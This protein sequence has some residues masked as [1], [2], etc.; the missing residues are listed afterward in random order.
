M[1]GFAGLISPSQREGE[2]GLIGMVTAMAER[3][4]HRGPDDHGAWA[5]AA[6]GV[7]LAHRRLSIVDLSPSGHQPMISQC[8]RYVIAFNGE[9]YN[10]RQLRDQLEQEC[11]LQWR[12]HSDTEV[13]LAAVSHWGLTR[14]LERANGMFAL[15]LWDRQ[16]RILHLA[17]DRA[18]EKPLY[19]GWSGGRF[20]FAS[21]L[22]ALV[23]LPDWRGEVDKEA[24]A[25]Y[26]RF[27]YVP[28]P[29]SIYRGISK[30][31]PGSTLSLRSAGNGEWKEEQR[32]YWS[33][34]EVAA[35]GLADPLA[36]PEREASAE[37]E[38]LLADAVALRMQADV[39]LGALLSGG[40]DS[41]LVV[42]LMQRQSQRPVRT[43]S[44][45]F[46]DGEFDES[47]A[48]EAVAT[49][50][51]TEHSTL[52]LQPR[53]LLAAV[54]HMAAIYDEPFADVSQVPTYLIS[55]FARQQVTVALSGDGGDELFFGYKR[56]VTGQSLW[57][58]LDRLPVA[59][60]RMVAATLARV[61]VGGANR[62]SA[63]FAA[64][65]AR[66]GRPGLLGD[67]LRKL[68]ELVGPADF[69]AFYRDF[70]SMWKQPQELLAGESVP[71]LGGVAA[72]SAAGDDLVA[73]MALIDFETYLP[74]DILV[75]V[76][77][78]SM[79]TS[80]E[81]RVPLLDHRLVEFAWRLPTASK[82]AGGQGKHVLREVLYRNVPRDLVDRP[83]KGFGVPL[84]DWLRGPLREWAGDLLDESRLRQQGLLDPVPVRQKWREHLSGDRNW[85]YQLWG[86]L[87]LQAW[88]EHHQ[89]CASASS[90][91]Q[92]PCFQL[93]PQR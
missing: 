68:A 9:I 64:L 50:L 69:E 77:R 21:E 75:K 78:A 8:Q 66:H 90:P 52:H 46:D 26:L 30:L 55:R 89:S 31:M 36:L 80:L 42:A 40:V 12:G 71:A 18:G 76:D 22:K 91:A 51:G 27:G 16:E 48:A 72:A 25:Q 10:F 67:K 57:R 45:G 37:L 49:R 17:R 65:M 20:A 61:P 86:V 85:A 82:L 88:L 44:V 24:L 38:S 63:P 4:R 35:A 15:A 93:T 53:D 1:C 74:D 6:A 41:S 43:F 11:R 47:A 29:R 70:V 14:A 92:Q 81:V 19:Y 28:A 59:V 56:Y 79:A 60:R 83:K 7:A 3:L 54:P 73:R 2:Q 23:G 34:A 32:R 33:I 39:P 13:L 62:L 58:T 87:M 84:A 5:D